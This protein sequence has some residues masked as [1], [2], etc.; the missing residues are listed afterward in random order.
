MDNQLM[1][2]IDWSDIFGA[3]APA[4]T[5]QGIAAA[6]TPIAG[7]MPRVSMGTGYS[8]ITF[9]PEQEERISAW[10]VSQLNKDPGPVRMDAGGIAL[11][12]IM[13]EYWPYMV[14]LAVGGGLLGYL[15]SG[16]N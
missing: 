4:A 15:L 1:R 12:V 11:K 2:G 10:L 14:G 3:L 9:T 8:E 16:K 7:S 13:R 6:L 5:A